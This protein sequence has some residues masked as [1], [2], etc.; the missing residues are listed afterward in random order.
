MDDTINKGIFLAPFHLENLDMF[1]F[2]TNIV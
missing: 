1:Q 2:Y